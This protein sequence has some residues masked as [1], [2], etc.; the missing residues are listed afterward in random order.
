MR[1]VKAV[2]RHWWLSQH[3]MHKASGERSDLLTVCLT[4]G[5]IKMDYC[6]RYAAHSLPSVQLPTSWHWNLYSPSIFSSL[7]WR[8]PLPHYYLNLSST[9]LCPL[10]KDPNESELSLN[11]WLFMLQFSLPLFTDLWESHFRSG[12]WLLYFR[13]QMPQFIVFVLLW[14]HSKFK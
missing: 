13:R 8:A 12:C 7:S 1:S 14:H 9:L 2:I 10:T 5:R 3:R 11:L 6:R 4:A